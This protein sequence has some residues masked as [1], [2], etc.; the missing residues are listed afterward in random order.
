MR[1]ALETFSQLA[2]GVVNKFAQTLEAKAPP[3][4]IYHYTNDLGLR[5]II[6]TGNLWFSDIFNQNDPSELRHGLLPAIEIMRIEADRVAVPE[7]KTF[8]KNLSGML[9]GGIEK[10]AHYFVCCF[11]TA[12]DDLG[13]WRAYADNGRGYALGF[14]AQLL[15]QA[16]V[17][18][19]PKPGRMTFPI[20]YGEDQLRAMYQKIIAEVLPLISL[21]RSYAGLSSD[22]LNSYMS[23]LSTILSL[24]IVR[25]ALFFKHGAYS[26]EAEY[27]FFELFQ[28]GPT[29]P[30][31]RY[32]SRPYSLIRY[33]EY[34]WR[35]VAPN[36][37]KHIRIGP[38]ADKRLAFEFAETCLREFHP[39]IGS[40]R[41]DQSTIPYRVM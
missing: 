32:R 17:A 12:E 16:F 33:R 28:R 37:L 26:N 4:T 11:S 36:A 7:A 24:P 6:E 30:D 15:E 39:V 25:A 2:E 10:T 38:S 41:I 13:Q 20:T 23:E 21:P 1:A 29:V 8:S 5:G 27:R 19:P 18:G 3:A 40:I 22:G 34:D 35:A 14:D 9:R 31:L